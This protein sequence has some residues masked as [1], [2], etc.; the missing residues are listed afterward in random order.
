VTISDLIT[1]VN[2]AQ[3][4]ALRAACPDGIPNGASVNIALIV[5]A[6]NHALNGCAS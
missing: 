4:S 1:L 5:Q 6:V 3:G 2:I